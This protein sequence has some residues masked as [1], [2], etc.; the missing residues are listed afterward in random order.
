MTGD[1]TP[2]AFKTTNF[3]KTWTSI[4]QGLP[5][6]QYVRTIREDPKNPDVVYLGTELGL[7]ASQDRGAHWDAFQQ[8]LPP[9]SVRDIQIQP[10]FNDL[11]LA[12][13]GRDAW[14]L[15]DVTPFE[16]LKRA[17]MNASYI[18]PVRQAFLYEIHGGNS[19]S[20]FL[21]AGQDPPFG[22]IATFYLKAP[23]KTNPTAEILDVNGHVVR[24]YTTHL[25]DGKPVPDLSNQAG[26]NRFTWDLSEDKPIAWNAAPDWNQ[27][28]SGAT[29]MP[30]HYTIVVHA[31]A[32]M[33]R[34]PVEVRPDPR[35]R[36]M[37]MNHAA[38]YAFE[39]RL[40]AQWSRVDL[41]LNTLSTV[42]EQADARKAAIAKTSPNEPMLARLDAI[43]AGAVALQATITSNPRGSQDDD[44]LRDIL[45]ERV[46]S[47][48]FTLD[49]FKAPTVEQKRESKIVEALGT[50]R[51]HAVDQFVNTELRSVNDALKAMKLAPLT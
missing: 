28:N 13:H 39:H 33:L 14:I 38:R 19:S 18:F 21:A 7:Y 3:G 5:A 45:R 16:Q 50:E 2:H 23:A 8:N 10:E 30:G 35:E 26:L 22:A 34:T 37:T 17:Q 48:I 24:H 41:A 29:V 27:F 20:T 42:Q 32:T 15:D 25:E 49:T 4:T 46:Q 11:L 43:K 47:L 6:D 9:A 31:G 51:L 36:D 1:H 12:T 40:L 44:F